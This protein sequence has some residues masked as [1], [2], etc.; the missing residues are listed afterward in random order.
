MTTVREV[1]TFLQRLAPPGLAAEWD[2]V[3]LLL[4]EGDAPVSRILTCLTVVPE[5]VAEAILECR[6]LSPHVEE[7]LERLSRFFEERPS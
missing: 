6:N 4:G 1:A 5:V 3:G 7:R 2:Y